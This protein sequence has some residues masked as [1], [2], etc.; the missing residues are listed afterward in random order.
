MQHE[1]NLSAGVAWRAG[2]WCDASQHRDL[3][4][5]DT[6]P[7]VKLGTAVGL[8]ATRPG[9]R[10]SGN[11]TAASARP[12]AQP[13]LACAD[14]ASAQLL[15]KIPV[16][17]N[18]PRM[19]NGWWSKRPEQLCA[20]SYADR[21]P[22]TLAVVVLA[23]RMWKHPRG[24]GCLRRRGHQEE[25]RRCRLVRPRADRNAAYGGCY[26]VGGGTCREEGGS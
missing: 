8:Q 3:Q 21:I 5:G 17:R 23:D 9:G 12:P 20:I 19:S 25:A 18:A 26:N 10:P 11:V 15:T 22:L 24:G 16:S 4:I 7:R 1:P 14:N 6:V 13:P 2:R